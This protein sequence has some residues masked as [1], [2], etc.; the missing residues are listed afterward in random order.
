MKGE[1][2]ESQE[3]FFV[4]NLCFFFVFMHCVLFLVVLLFC[5]CSLLTPLLLFTFT[6]H[7]SLPWVVV[8]SR[9]ASLLFIVVHCFSP[10]IVVYCV[11]LFS[12][13]VVA[14][15]DGALSLALCCCL[16]WFIVLILCCRCLM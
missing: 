6:L 7:H 14:S 4:V 1:D 3:V 10:Y 12:P 15:Y 16:F 5:I 11:A 8:C 2:Y 9:L 13:Y